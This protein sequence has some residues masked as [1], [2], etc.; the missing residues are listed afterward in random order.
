MTLKFKQF[1]DCYIGRVLVFFNV[2]L[3]RSVG[4]LLKRDHSLNKPPRHILVIKML[5]L[6]SIIMASDSIFSLRKKYPAAKI[7]LLCGRSIKP[8]VAPI[9]LFDEIWTNDDRN[10]LRMAWSGCTLLARSWKLKGLWVIDLEVYSI[11]TTL[12][13]AWTCAVNRFGFQLNKVYFRNY[14]NTHNI[15]FNQFITVN[16]NYEML[17][18][19]A[20]VTEIEPFSI[21]FPDSGK[22]KKYIA[23]NNT[24]SEL[25]GDLRKIPA[26]TLTGICGHIVET[27]PYDIAFTGAPSDRESIGTFI[28]NHLSPI[29]QRIRNTAGEFGFEE[30]YHF[31]QHEC[32]AMISIDSAPLHIAMKLGMRTLSL[33]G[34]INPLHR[35]RFSGQ[36]KHL[37]Y[38]LATE[39]SPCIHHTEVVPCGG[40]NICMKHMETHEINTLTDNLLKHV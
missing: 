8:G 4:L 18:K 29:K 25:G 37:S 32:V 31:L 10:I 28:D 39:C 40:D 15:Y 26:L 12:F 38:Y 6:G 34:P 23:I 17:V 33:W 11:L 27:T 35:F 5:G 22:E 21:S 14:L 7:I 1:I 16:Q 30:Y 2:I 13:S 36:H 24:C 9:G 19:A 3:V 20:G